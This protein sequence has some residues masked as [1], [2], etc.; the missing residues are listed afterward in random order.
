MEMSSTQR[1]ILANQYRLMSLLDSEN[2]A[3]YARFET[4]VRGGFALELRE[5]DK[6]FS[7]ISE[8]ECRIVRDTLEMYHALH[9]SYNNLAD[10]SAVTLH[11]LLFNGYC[12]VREWKY[13]NYLRFVILNEGKYQEFMRC[14]HGCD[15]Q[16]PMW[17]KYTKMLDVWRAC[18]HE[19]HLSIEEILNILNA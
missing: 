18:P 19:Y 1:L 4:I 16:T 11:R 7:N 8:Q 5:L 6:D 13:L 14:E 10:K 2:T 15:S 12:A 17:D 3:K 9:I